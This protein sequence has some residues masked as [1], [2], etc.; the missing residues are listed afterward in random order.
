MTELSPTEQA[1]KDYGNQSRLNNDFKSLIA[2]KSKL[3][4]RLAR[5]N[6]RIAELELRLHHV[7][8]ITSWHGETPLY[9]DTTY[10]WWDDRVNKDTITNIG[11]RVV[12]GALGAQV[13]LNQHTLN[14][15]GLYV[16]EGRSNQ[17]ERLL[18]TQFTLEQAVNKARD[19]C[20]S[21]SLESQVVS[22]LAGK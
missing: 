4:K 9:V 13:Y 12:G 18:G 3:E 7:N 14:T 17:R 10:G 8:S 1:I 20:A 15:Y 22:A 16:Y 6:Q 21:G 5:V 19:W 11:F 2:E